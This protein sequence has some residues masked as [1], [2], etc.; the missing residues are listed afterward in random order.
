MIKDGDIP[1]LVV[2]RAG[3]AFDA[4]ADGVIASPQNRV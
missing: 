2:E 4:G 1:D 3:R